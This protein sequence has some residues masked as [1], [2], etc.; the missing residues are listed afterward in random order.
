M[1]EPATPPGRRREILSLAWPVILN[2]VLL[3]FVWIVDMGS[4]KAY[5]VD[6]DTYQT[7]ITVSGLVGPY[8]YSDMT[9]S[10][11]NL[12]VNPPN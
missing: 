7:V 4:S 3:T 11:L 12:Q 9:G 10:G 6:P 2:N 5:K 8:T 1:S